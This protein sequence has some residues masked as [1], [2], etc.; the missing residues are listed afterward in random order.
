M[1]F[2]GQAIN[3]LVIDQHYQIK[4]PEINDDLILEL[5]LALHKKRRVPSMT[6]DGYSY[7]VEEPIYYKL[8]PYRLIFLMDSK[9]SFIGVINA[10]RVKEKK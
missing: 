1:I 5:I 10:F 7:F 3:E 2:N 6:K 8:K 4:H 9:A